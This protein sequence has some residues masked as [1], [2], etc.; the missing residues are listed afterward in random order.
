M[1]IDDFKKK[2]TQWSRRESNPGPGRGDSAHCECWTTN[3]RP[4]IGRRLGSQWAVAPQRTCMRGANCYC[5]GVARYRRHLQLNAT[6]APFDYW[7]HVVTPGPIHTVN[8]LS[9]LERQNT[10]LPWL[11]QKRQTKK[12]WNAKMAARISIW[13]PL[14]H[15]CVN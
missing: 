15:P 5:S 2:K 6:T 1:I 9:Q 13:I 4:W 3:N 11:F 8:P 12:K 14:H 7:R 10:A